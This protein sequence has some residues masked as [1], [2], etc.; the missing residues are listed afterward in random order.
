MKINQIKLNEWLHR[1]AGYND[2]PSLFLADYNR[3][4]FSALTS[5]FQNGLQS[6]RQENLLTV[7]FNSIAGNGLTT[8]MLDFQMMVYRVASQNFLYVSSEM[9]VGIWIDYIRNGHRQKLST[10]DDYLQ[11]GDTWEKFYAPF[12]DGII[13]DDIEFILRKETS[14]YALNNLIDNYHKNKKTVILTLHCMTSR[15][16]ENLDIGSKQLQSR[17]LQGI[18]IDMR[19][20][21]HKDREEFIQYYSDKCNIFLSDSS[22]MSQLRQYKS[23]RQ[24]KDIIDALLFY[25]KDENK[26]V[27]SKNEVM[28]AEYAVESGGYH[29]DI[30]H[31]RGYHE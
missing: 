23:I 3:E 26:R 25:S 12:V 5:F 18:C 29:K 28:F 22:N 11:L 15:E 21:S 27:F 17:I 20:P 10:L 24:I 19:E 6:E 1:Y 2:V 9:F 7:F 4:T 30:I 31:N 8:M 16:F 14:M 13:I